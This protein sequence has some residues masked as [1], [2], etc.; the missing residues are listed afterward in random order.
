MARRLR[1]RP[2]RAAY[3]CPQDDEDP[4]LWPPCTAARDRGARRN[5]GHEP[6]CE[7]D[8]P[9]QDRQGPR[10]HGLLPRG[11]GEVT[12][13]ARR[14]PASSPTKDSTPAGSGDSPIRRTIALPT[15]I[16]SAPARRRA[17]TWSGVV[18]PNPTA[19]G[20]SVTD[21]RTRNRDGSSGGSSWRVPVVPYR[22][23]TQRKP[24]EAE[25]IARA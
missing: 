5:E 3:A 14:P 25:A 7:L 18:T 21:R 13:S 1:R 20:R 11:T 9:P 12:A 22:A 8:S 24:R 16:P 19:S 23:T 10:G 2:L 17:R 6:H 4:P 15:T